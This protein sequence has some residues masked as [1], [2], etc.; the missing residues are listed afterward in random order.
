MFRS[1]PGR[2]LQRVVREWELY[3]A[4]VPGDPEGNGC[5]CLMGERELVE[6]DEDGKMVGGANLWMVWVLEQVFQHAC[7]GMNQNATH[8]LMGWL[9]L[10]WTACVTVDMADWSISC[11]AQME[12]IDSSKEFGS[13]MSTETKV[14]KSSTVGLEFKVGWTD[15]G[16]ASG[17]RNTLLHGGELNLTVGLVYGHGWTPLDR[18]LR[19]RNHIVEDTHLSW[20]ACLTLTAR[21]PSS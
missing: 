5:S 14:L 17:R 13:S 4:V 19:T 1:R 15:A 2:G 21:L 9:H 3:Q 7:I 6:V 10:R 18:M 20:F 8:R 11:A 16:S 12:E